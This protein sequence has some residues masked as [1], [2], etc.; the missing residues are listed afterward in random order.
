MWYPRQIQGR[1]LAIFF[2][3]AAVTGAFGGVFAYLI[4]YMDGKAGLH[5][6]QWIVCSYVS[7]SPLKY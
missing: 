3:A 6:W 5:G 4:D 7:S 2:S 1:R